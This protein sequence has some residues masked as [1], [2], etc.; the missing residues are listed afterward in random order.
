[1]DVDEGNLLLIVIMV[2][3]R[4]IFTVLKLSKNEL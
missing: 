4:Y 1:M 3:K 2:V